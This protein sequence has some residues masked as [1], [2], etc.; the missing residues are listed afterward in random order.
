MISFR[1]QPAGEFL[2][3]ASLWE[4]GT[5]RK[6]PAAAPVWG[7]SHVD[8]PRVTQAWSPSERGCG[9]PSLDRKGNPVPIRRRPAATGRLV[10][11]DSKQIL[12]I[13]GNAPLRDAGQV[14]RS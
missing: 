5:V 3:W 7:A 8:S 10:A 4:A 2:P 14:I 12:N 6:K 1:L 9:A 13:G 11:R